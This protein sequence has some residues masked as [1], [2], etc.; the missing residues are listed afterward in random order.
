MFPNVTDILWT[1]IFSDKIMRL[2]VNFNNISSFLAIALIRLPK[3]WNLSITQSFFPP[4]LLQLH[5]PQTWVLILPKQ[6]FWIQLCNK[7]HRLPISVPFCLIHRLYLFSFSQ[8][9]S[10][11]NKILSSFASWR[12]NLSRNVSIASA[13]LIYAATFSVFLW[14]VTSPQIEIARLR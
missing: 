6:K 13:T 3:T 12:R 1:L 8:T 2:V 7:R 4:K 14:W 11:F 10:H 5:A 9:F